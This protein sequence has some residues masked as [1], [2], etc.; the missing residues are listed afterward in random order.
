MG[1]PTPS[2]KRY[3]VVDPGLCLKAE[4]SQ[5]GCAPASYTQLGVVHG[6]HFRLLHQQ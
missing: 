3:S 2:V 6:G 5:D 4:V 1:A